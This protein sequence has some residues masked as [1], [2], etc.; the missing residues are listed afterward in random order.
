MLS[1][2]FFTPA[3]P[4]IRPPTDSV[5]KIWRYMS[6]AKYCTL[7][8]TRQLHFTSTAL[9][10]DRWEGSHGLWHAAGVEL[11]SVF[12]KVNWSSMSLK[13]FSTR[14]NR[15]IRGWTYA[16]CWHINPDDSEAMWKLYASD[17]GSVAIQSTY[18]R[19]R[20]V[21]TP[22]IGIG[23]VFY[24]NFYATPPEKSP[25]KGYP[26]PFVFKRKSLKHERELRALVQR[27][28]LTSDGVVD[29]WMPDPPPAYS[30]N[31][32]L[33]KLI[34]AVHVQ[35]DAPQWLVDTVANI[36]K[37]NHVNIPVEQIRDEALF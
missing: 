10:D 2:N 5:A 35:P 1:E 33:H 11:I 22:D 34:E 3:H 12:S 29:L 9:F 26:T 36:T 21:L 14:W 30:V 8:R 4:N 7:L 27:V 18:G 23:R 19:L 37:L 17:A 16:N 31:V 13:E 6:F 24:S 32:D 15:W 20:S 28:P 25:F